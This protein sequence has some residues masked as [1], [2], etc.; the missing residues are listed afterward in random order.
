M[1][2]EIDVLVLGTC[3]LRKAHQPKGDGVDRWRE[4]IP[5]D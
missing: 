4:E 5:L 1:R 3:V 2:T